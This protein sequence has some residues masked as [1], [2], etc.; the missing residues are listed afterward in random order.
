M[1]VW[2]INK[3]KDSNSNH[4]IRKVEKRT[5]QL[6]ERQQTPKVVKELKYLEDRM[7]IG[8]MLLDRWYE[9]HLDN[10]LENQS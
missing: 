9:T 5:R 3:L 1:E 10:R 4:I 2:G 6:M 8:Q 7:K